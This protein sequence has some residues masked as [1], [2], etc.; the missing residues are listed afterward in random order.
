M[1]KVEIYTKAFCPYCARAKSLLESKGVAY[2]EY[3]ISM[4]GPKRAEMLERARGGSTVPQ[5]F[6][7]GTHVGGC[8][9]IHA[10][11]R[12]GKLDPLLAA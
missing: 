12:A 9:D 8:D 1:A 5:I 6:I 2:E 11:D 4:G 10:L 3:D 7:D